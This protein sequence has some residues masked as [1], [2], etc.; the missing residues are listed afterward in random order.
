MEIILMPLLAM[1]VVYNMILVSPLIEGRMILVWVCL[2]I[3][4]GIGLTDILAL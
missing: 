4:L 1:V 2:L 3:I